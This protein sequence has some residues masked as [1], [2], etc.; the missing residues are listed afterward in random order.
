MYDDDVL[1]ADTAAGYVG[2][3]RECV[4]VEDGLTVERAQP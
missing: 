3:G 1:V 4:K 2:C